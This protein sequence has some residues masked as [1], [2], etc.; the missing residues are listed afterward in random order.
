MQILFYSRKLILCICL[1][2]FI[3]IS[4]SQCLSSM[5]PVG[6]T[7]NLLG[8]EKNSLRVIS[9]YKYGNSN[10]YYEKDKRSGYNRIMRAYYNYVSLILGYG[11]TQK[12]TIE[13]ESG[14]FINKTQLYN[15]TPQVVLTGQ[16]LSNVVF[17]GK[18]AIYSNHQKRNYISFSAGPKIPLSRK[19]KTDN[20]V[21][22]PDELQPTMGAYGAVTNITFVAENSLKG[23]RYFYINRLECNGKNIDNSQQGLSIFNSVFFSKHLMASWIKGDWT[24]IFQLRNE[25]RMK[26]HESNGGFEESSGGTTFILVPQLNYVLFEK[27]YISMLVDIPVYQYFNGTQL[28]TGTAITINISKTFNSSEN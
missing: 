13:A 17:L 8:L 2:C 25:T 22:L 10:H 27:W 14:C 4:Y 15:V 28:G 19:K 5:N 24:A 6:G 26:N 18:Y 11:L 12:F 9:F 7:E 16:G 23:M 1:T 3:F 20:N 21:I